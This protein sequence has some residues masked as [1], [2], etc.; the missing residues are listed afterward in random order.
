MKKACSVELCERD[1]HA[2]G[3]C[4]KHYSAWLAHGNPLGCNRMLSGTVE[5]R[6]RHHGWEVTAS[7]CWEFKMKPMASGHCRMMIDG[8]PILVHRLAYE[9]W[10]APIPEGLLVRHKCDNPPCMN[11]DHLEP[12]THQDNRD[13]VMLRG[14]PI[15]K[16]GED[17]YAAILDEDKVRSIRSLY[18]NGSRQTE[19]SKMFGVSNG[20]IR[21]V[22]HRIS[23]KD[24]N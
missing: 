18:A 10:V 24:V 14:N 2:R 15:F 11:P 12:G 17:H 1:A 19:L 16:R 5:E 22:V 4:S 13:D 3:W 6:L 20:A 8:K 21:K 7:D 23:W 9:L